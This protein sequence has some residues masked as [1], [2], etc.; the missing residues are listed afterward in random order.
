MYPSDAIFACRR[1][2]AWLKAKYGAQL[3]MLTGGDRNQQ[4]PDDMFDV[5][6]YMDADEIV[7]CAAGAAQP[8][9]GLMTQMGMVNAACVELERIPNLAGVPLAVFPGRITLDHIQGALDQMLPAY[10]K[11]AQL[12]ALNILAIMRGIFPDTYVVGHPGDPQSPEIITDAD[13]LMGIIGEVAH[14]QVITVGNPTAGAQAAEMAQDRLERS[15]RIVAGLPAEVN[16]ESGSN[17]RTARRGEQVLGSAIDMPIQ[18]AQDIMA[19]SKQIELKVG[20]AIQKGWFGKK[21]TSFYIPNRGFDPDKDKSDYVPDEIFETDLNYIKYS[22]PG[23]DANSIVIAL[24]QRINMGTMSIETAMEVDPAIEDAVM[25]RVRVQ[26]EG[27]TR[28]LLTSI[29]QGAQQGT[30]LPQEIAL[31]AKSL[32]STK[33]QLFDVVIKVHEEMQKRQAAQQQL[34]PGAPGAMPGLGGGPPGQQPGQPPSNFTG[35]PSSPALA[36]ILGNLAAPGKQGAAE[37]QQAQPPQPSPA[38]AGT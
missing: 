10:H 13:G 38:M 18:E 17:I 26:T 5:L 36:Q 19:V 31:I 28:A 29:E 3:A 22:M 16:G 14:G 25:E 7:L 32:Y 27:M 12:D 8:R 35:P 23:T 4:R 21:P 15:Q 11:A 33:E 20:V 24:G 9:G 2:R 37:A 30:V 1:P 34:P 6:E